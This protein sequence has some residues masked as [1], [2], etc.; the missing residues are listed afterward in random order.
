MCG[1]LDFDGSCQPALQPR[2]A[3]AQAFHTFVFVFVHTNSLHA[4]T[5]VGMCSQ[6][7]ALLTNCWILVSCPRTVARVQLS[8]SLLMEVCCIP[9][10]LYE[11]LCTQRLKFT[12]Q[13]FCSFHFVQ[14][15][16]FICCFMAFCIELVFVFRLF[17]ACTCNVSLGVPHYQMYVLILSSFFKFPRVR[18]TMP[19]SSIQHLHHP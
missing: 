1:P 12:R 8:T 10:A 4:C 13:P 17:P 6:A 14:F 3:A 5:V 11:N 15:C 16:Q 7:A 9:N 19:F 18:C 2:K